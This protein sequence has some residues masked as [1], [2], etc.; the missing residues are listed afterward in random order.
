MSY[1]RLGDEVP[2]NVLNRR[3]PTVDSAARRFDQIPK[4]IEHGARHQTPLSLYVSLFFST[5][6]LL[7]GVLM[8]PLAAA[9]STTYGC[10]EK[11]NYKVAK[12]GVYSGNAVTV[13]ED[14][15]D[16]ACRFNVNGANVESPNQATVIAALNSIRNGQ[17]LDLGDKD[18]SRHLA[19]F[20]IS[21]SPMKEPPDDLLELFRSHHSILKGCFGG[22]SGSGTHRGFSFSCGTFGPGTRNYHT[23]V[24]VRT[25]EVVV[26]YPGNSRRSRTYIPF[27]VIGNRRPL[28]LD[29][30]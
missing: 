24:R 1:K 2:R 25:L 3:R 30:R 11:S 17:I 15:A 12:V 22:S 20:T 27:H 5:V 19:F 7:L 28:P 14:S 18:F 26:K 13:D 10:E 23:S 29:L 8:N 4:A 6:T 21:A 16:R 9:D